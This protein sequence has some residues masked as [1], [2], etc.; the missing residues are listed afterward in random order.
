MSNKHVQNKH[1]LYDI[2]VDDSSILATVEPIQTLLCKA[3]EAGGATILHS[4]FHQ[5][6]PHGVTGFL[7]LAESHLSIHT[8]VEEGF[9]ALDIFTCGPMN[10]DKV[11]EVIRDGLKPRQASVRR[12]VRGGDSGSGL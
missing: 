4:H 12:I 2:W 5:F 7:L 3:A 10:T 8:W 1:V 6:D 11:L 9:A